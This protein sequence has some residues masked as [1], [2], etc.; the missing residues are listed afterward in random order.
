MLVKIKGKLSLRTGELPSVIISECV[1]WKTNTSENV[2]VEKQV[3]I[4]TL[5][6]KYDTT[7][8]KLNNDILKILQSYLGDSEV[9]VKCSSTNKAYKLNINVNVDSFVLNELRFY[10]GDDFIKVR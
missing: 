6:L 9:I 4:P 7:N 2:V 3:K 10:L 1:E 5:Y 8:E